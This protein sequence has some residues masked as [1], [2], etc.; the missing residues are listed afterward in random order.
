MALRRWD[1]GPGLACPARML[2]MW[3]AGGSILSPP[4][5]SERDRWSLAPRQHGRG[6]QNLVLRRGAALAFV[7]Q[8]G[9]HGTGAAPN[10]GFLP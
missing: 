7:R 8:A 4:G 2:A 3:A 1:I 5:P 6:W 9:F 10:T